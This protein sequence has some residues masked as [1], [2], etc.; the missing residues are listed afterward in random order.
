M[1]PI[2]DDDR[3]FFVV[4]VGFFRWVEGYG[5]AQAVDVLTLATYADQYICWVRGEKEGIRRSVR[6]PSTC[7]IDQKS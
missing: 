7:P 1:V 4:R 3:E 2:A 6:A 5:G